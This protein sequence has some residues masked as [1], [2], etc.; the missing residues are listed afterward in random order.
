MI[1]QNFCPLATV[2]GIILKLLMCGKSLPL[3][4]TKRGSTSGGGKVGLGAAG[5]ATGTGVRVGTMR[6]AVG[7]GRGVNV[8][9][10]VRVG[11]GV[12]VGTTNATL[13]GPALF[14]RV[15]DDSFCISS[16]LAELANCNPATADVTA[17]TV[18]NGPT[19]IK[20]QNINASRVTARSLPASDKP[21][22]KTANSSQKLGPARRAL[23]RGL[24]E[25]RCAARGACAGVCNG[26]ALCCRATPN[27][28]AA[29]LGSMCAVLVVGDA[30]T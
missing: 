21:L 9:A 25:E 6:T 28:V 4:G 11:I 12:L 18:V 26:G 30:L 13:A 7:C 16:A 5:A 23:A 8:G 3:P 10:G 24:C 15:V 29:G 27:I 22:A 2:A 1:R 19:T 17:F 14:A 20:N